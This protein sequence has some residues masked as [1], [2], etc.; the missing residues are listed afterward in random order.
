MESGGWDSLEMLSLAA[1]AVERTDESP[2]VVREGA[3]REGACTGRRAR[4][5]NSR[6]ADD[7]VDDGRSKPSHVPLKGH[8][9]GRTGQS[10]R[11]RADS[12]KHKVS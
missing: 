6:Y 3:Q 5:I 2:P 1:A 4:K 10:S 12:N 11:A 7:F 8:E 9:P